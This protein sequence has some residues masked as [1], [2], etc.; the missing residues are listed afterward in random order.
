MNTGKNIL[1]AFQVVNETHANLNKM[2]SALNEI[3]ASNNFENL[4]NNP[5]GFMR[6]KSDSNTIGWTVR[7]M[8]KLFRKSDEEDKTDNTNTIYAFDVWFGPSCFED[9]PEVTLSKFEYDSG[10]FNG[11]KP[12]VSDHSLFHYPVRI[13]DHFK[14]AK[15]GDYTI[16]TPNENAVNKYIGLKQV[17]FK[18][19]RLMDITTENLDDIFKQMIEI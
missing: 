4:I 15:N 17:T 19:I 5:P 8:I 18:R 10:I 2:F 16:S 14:H 6:W 1:N 13:N 12:A 3:A 9:S 7:S 11:K